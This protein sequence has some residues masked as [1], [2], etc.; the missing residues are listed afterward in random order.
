MSEGLDGKIAIITGGAR[1]IGEHIAAQFV[2][3][4]TTVVIADLDDTAAEETATRL[5]G[6]AHA[7]SVDVADSTTV[8]ELVFHTVDHF[9]GMRIYINNAGCSSNRPTVEMT[10]SDWREALRVDLDGMFFG[11]REAGRHFRAAGGGVIVNLSSICGYRAVQPEKHLG[12]DV[13]KAGVAHMTR[14]LAAEWAPFNIRVNAV[15]PGYTR[16]TP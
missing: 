4:G 13:A 11:A 6:R 16:Q 2:S 15:A 9:G 1:G 7:M 10:D 8:R 3:R 5:G 14:I 12:Y